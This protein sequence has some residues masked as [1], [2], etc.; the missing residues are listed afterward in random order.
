[1]S[2]S[3]SAARPI[4]NWDRTLRNYHYQKQMVI[5]EPKLLRRPILTNG[6]KIVIGYNPDAFKNMAK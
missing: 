4:K 5:K 2:F 3:R 6:D 1:M